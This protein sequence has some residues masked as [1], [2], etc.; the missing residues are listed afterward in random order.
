MLLWGLGG[1]DIVDP[2]GPRFALVAKEMISTHQWIMPHR[3]E[4]SYP[5]KPPFFFWSIAFFSMI[6]GE[7]NAFTARIPS[8]LAAMGVLFFIFQWSKKDAENKIDF[9]IAYLTSFILLT[10]FLFFYQA[11]T[12]QIDM[13]LCFLVTASMI[14]GYQLISGERKSIWPMAIFMGLATITKGPIGFILPMGVCATYIFFSKLEWKKLPWKSLLI[15]F[16]IPLTWLCFLLIE[17]IKT[18][19]WDYFQNLLFKQTIVR[20]ANSW[21]HEKPFYYFFITILWDFLPWSPF[22]IMTLIFP[23]KKWQS[24]TSKEKFAWCVCL[25]VLIFFSIPK[26]KRHIYILPIFPFIA[27]IVALSFH[28]YLKLSVFPKFYKFLFGLFFL[29]FLLTSIALM[30]IGLNL[31]QLPNVD[32]L[33]IKIPFNAVFNFGLSLFFI[34]IAGFIALK[35]ITI[36]FPLALLIILMMQANLF[37]FQ[38]VLPTIDPHRSVRGFMQVVNHIVEEESAT[39]ILGMVDFKEGFRLY[40]NH[41]IIE[42]NNVKGESKNGEYGIEKFWELYPDG[43]L[44]IKR[45]IWEDYIREKPIKGIFIYEQPI[46]LQKNYCLIRKGY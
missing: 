31:F 42:L 46:S 8:A 25:F 2:D 45:K 44:I 13:M 26:G 22:F 18:N 28:Y 7:V 43:W 36:K 40:G 21:H 35:K 20:Y 11:R 14:E 33:N 5:D 10:S 3:N 12:A 15:S 24:F 29:V 32:Q 17:V 39:P 9:K 1:Y 16:I 6:V 37:T 4:Y 23:V 30:I 19:E 34:S 27:Y 38:I 41:H